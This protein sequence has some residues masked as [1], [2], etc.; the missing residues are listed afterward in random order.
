MGKSRPWQEAMTTLTGSPNMNASTIQAY[1][2]PLKEW[3]DKQNE[4]RNCGW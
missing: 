1:F 3:L 4:E 2:A